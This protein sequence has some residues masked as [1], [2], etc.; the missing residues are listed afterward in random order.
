MPRAEYE[1]ALAR[2]EAGTPLPHDLVTLSHAAS[3]GIIGFPSITKTNDEQP[4][5]MADC[6]LKHPIRTRCMVKWDDSDSTWYPGRVTGYK[7]FASGKGAVAKANVSVKYDDGEHMWHEIDQ[8]EIKHAARSKTLVVDGERAQ[9]LTSVEEEE[10]SLH[11]MSEEN[12]MAGVIACISEYHGELL[13]SV[14]QAAEHMDDELRAELIDRVKADAQSDMFTVGAHDIVLPMMDVETG[15]LTQVM[16]AVVSTGTEAVTISPNEA[17]RWHLP[18]THKEYLQSPHRAQWR[19]GMELKM[20][21]YE[22]VPTWT[23]VDIKTV[24]RGTRIY[25]LK[26]AYGMKNVPDSVNLK[27]APRLCLVG[28]GMDPTIFPSYADVGRKITLNIVGAILSAFMEYF[29]AHQ[30]DTSDAFQNTVVDGSDGEKPGPTLY[31]YQ[32]PDFETKGENN[33]TLVCKHRTAFQG[34]IDSPRVYGA[35]VRPMLKSAGFHPLMYDPES[36]IYH[37]GPTKGTCTTLDEIVKKLQTV[38]PNSPGHPPHGYALMVRHV[39]DKVMIVTDPKITEYMVGHVRNTYACTYTGWKKVLG[40]DAVIDR[41]ERTVAFE[42]P[43]VL[44]AAKNRFLR[45]TSIIT[46]RHS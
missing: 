8:T 46:P 3:R 22:A 34:R 30:A 41:D 1:A 7:I 35:K 4:S 2:K 19:T 31:S 13:A 5:K 33:A 38:E 42:C 29:T 36:F 17:T 39:D 45:D 16:A 23:L 37:E 26:W 12:E 25:R 21:K 20:E 44:E 9:P 18:K 28:T 43:S 40:W 15:E 10:D 6:K 14:I 11:K 32:A 27:F 24:P